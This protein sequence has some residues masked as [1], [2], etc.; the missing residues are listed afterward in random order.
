MMNN[1]TGVYI[2]LPFC[3][4]KCP[5]CDFYSFREGADGV[6]ADAYV[7]ALICE[8]ASE[9]KF[10]ADTVYFG[11]GTPSLLGEKRIYK[12]LNALAPSLDGECEITLECNPKTVD[13]NSL[14][15]YRAA[16]V[17]R[18]SVGAQSFCDGE[19]RAL[20]RLHTA[21][22]AVN[23][24]TD[25]HRAGFDN[26]SL[27]LMLATP[28]Q[29]ASSLS[30]SVR[31]A[32]SLGVSH[33]SAYILTIEKNTRF[34]KAGVSLPEDD[35][36]AQMYLNTVYGLNAAGIKQYEISNF[37]AIGFESRHNLKYWRCEEYKGFGASAHSFENGVRRCHSRS[38]A[39]YIKT[40]GR[41]IKVTDE[42]AGGFTEYAMLRLRLCEGLDLN[43]AKKDTP[44]T[45]RR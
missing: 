39:E 2:H 45:P 32:V 16:G 25:A 36:V 6:T 4:S 43:A 19:L 20:G 5:Y 29:T 44:P 22:E 11:G 34:Y 37:A 8:I 35:T 18:L 42:K 28:G 3:L 30:Q 23:A 7:N 15:A 33:V 24:V 14:K 13:F 10:C 27:D 26:V 21:S 9:D 17:N 41:I 40:R 38:A 31:T 1:M 12:I